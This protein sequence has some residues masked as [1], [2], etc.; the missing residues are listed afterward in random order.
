MLSCG[1]EF[2][3][4]SVNSFGRDL[5][6]DQILGDRIKIEIMINTNNK[7]DYSDG[8]IKSKP[9]D[10]RSSRLSPRRTYRYRYGGFPLNNV[11]ERRRV[12]D[13]IACE[14]AL[15]SF[16]YLGKNSLGDFLE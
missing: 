16:L 8:N 6:S 9:C 12:R 7:E 11:S 14:F 2:K 1:A 5:F 3:I 10:I 15:Q 4:T 13:L